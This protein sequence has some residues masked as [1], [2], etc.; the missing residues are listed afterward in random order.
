MRL[1]EPRRT[2]AASRR[3][4]PPVGPPSPAL[5]LRL[6]HIGLSPRL[7]Y[8]GHLA[9]QALRYLPLM[10][11]FLRGLM[12]GTAFACASA[13]FAWS[14]ESEPVLA[15]EPALANDLAAYVAKTDASFAWHE[16][17]SGRLGS[18][19]YVEYLMTSQM[20]R[21][22][23]WKHQ[24]YV[25]RPANMIRGTRHG[26]LFIHGGRWKPEYEAERKDTALPR[27]AQLFARLAET[28]RAPVAV[29]RQVPFQP[30]FERREDALIAYTFDQYL[31]TGEGDWPLLLPMVKSA[32]RAMDA[33]Q[34]IASKRWNVSL[35]SF[36][37]TG[38]SKRGWTAWLTAAVDKR[39]MAVAPMVIDVLNMH[40]QMDHQRAT[41][42]D[43]SNEIQDYSALDLPARLQSERGQALLSMVDPFSYRDRLTQPKL[44]L[45]STNDRYWPLDALNLY[46]PGLPEPKRVIYLPNQG[47][48]LRD[49]KRVI[50]E[51]SAIHRYAAA[52]KPLPRTTWSFAVGADKLTIAIKANRPTQ[53]A[54]IWTATSATRDFRDARWTARKCSR[55]A[56]GYACSTGLGAEGYTAA[57]GETSFRDEGSPAFSTTTT[58]CISPPLPGESPEC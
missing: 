13:S 50:A 12:L 35:D 24:L 6:T 8:C 27:E 40:V 1:D 30:I 3:G 26:L 34:D 15:S 28:I 56:D 58:V 10:V 4:S 54:L 32:T 42:G 11:H 20:W 19:E 41:W 44:I 23:P 14:S 53:R 16:V 39:V 5:V 37:V 25:L 55:A 47:H 9:C 17:T 33:V 18:T 43:F 2:A 45:L 57:F 49:A 36:T 38:A 46:W 21:G 31:Q 22:I 7:G 29:L 51:L 48:G 52:G